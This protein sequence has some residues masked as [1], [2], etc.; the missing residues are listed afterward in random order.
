EERHMRR[1]AIAA[2]LVCLAI[3]VVQAE[4]LTGYITKIDGD[5]VTFSP[6]RKKGS[7]DSPAEMTFQLSKDVKVAQG[8]LNK[9]T[10]KYEATEEIPD[11]LRNPMFT[12]GKAR[13][14]ITINNNRDRIL[15]ILSIPLKKKAA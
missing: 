11:G 8:K 4:E 2:T 13:A 9:D 15:Q 14:R 3:G 12:T 1:V 5:R 7:T 6:L 10:K